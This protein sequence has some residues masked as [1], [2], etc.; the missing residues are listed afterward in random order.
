MVKL[1]NITI[2]YIVYK[3]TLIVCLHVVCHSQVLPP[4]NRTGHWMGVR[5][6]LK[7]EGHGLVGV[8]VAGTG[9]H[10]GHG[11]GVL[12]TSAVTDRRPQGQT[13]STLT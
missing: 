2:S 10:W 12:R 6:Q 13:L 4:G 7:V 9:T 1:Y 5:V 3:Y 11:R 8:G